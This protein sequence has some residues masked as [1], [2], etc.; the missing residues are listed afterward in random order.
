MQNRFQ[1]YDRSLE[2]SIATTS[3]CA[4]TGQKG[5]KKRSQRHASQHV[6]TGRKTVEVAVQSQKIPSASEAQSTQPEPVK[7]PSEHKAQQRPPQQAKRRETKPLARSQSLLGFAPNLQPPAQQSAAVVSSEYDV[8]I[9]RV[10]HSFLLDSRQASLNSISSSV[11][12]QRLLSAGHSSGIDIHSW[13]VL[14]SVATFKHISV[15]PVQGFSS[16][17]PNINPNIV[18]NILCFYRFLQGI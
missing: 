7:R 16:V 1:V 17:Q 9:S 5:Y 3:Q 10:P 2:A 13:L 12:V 14:P 4:G 6:H 11:D 18:H 15:Q 8:W